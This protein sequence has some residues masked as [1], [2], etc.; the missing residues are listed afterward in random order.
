MSPLPVRPLSDLVPAALR[1][2][3]ESAFGTLLEKL[4][5]RADAKVV[6]CERGLG[7]GDAKIYRYLRGDRHFPAAWLALLPPAVELLYLEERASHHAMTLAPVGDHEGDGRT[8]HT[9]V[10]ELS[11]VIRAAAQG[12]AD[13]HLSVADADQEEAEILEAQRAL[14]DRLAYLRKVR[15]A[16]GAVVE[17][18]RSR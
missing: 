15:A 16:R 12:E 9:I 2:Q 17:M 3:V 10:A 8:L 1:K 11:D 5:H 13:G 7:I 4:I 6:D 14:A 18:R